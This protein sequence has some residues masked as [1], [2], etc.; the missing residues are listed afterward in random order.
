MRSNTNRTL[1]GN[2]SSHGVAWLAAPAAGALFFSSL[3]GFA[4]VRQDGY[5][6]ATKAVSELGAIG[7]SGAFMFNILGMVLPGTLVA[8]FAMRMMRLPGSRVGPALLAASGV[9]LAIA[10]LFPANME[11]TSSFTSA[12]HLVGA[13]GCGACWAASLFWLGAVFARQPTLRVWSR[14]TPWF[15]LFLPVHVGWQVAYRTTGL[16]YPG[17]GQRIAFLGYFLWLAISGILLWRA[18]NRMEFR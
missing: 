13:L 1:E 7:A 8:L 14:V 17:W 9:L 6:H 4:A 16:V 12:A 2:K 5:A 3:L 15:L 18:N 11:D 10:G